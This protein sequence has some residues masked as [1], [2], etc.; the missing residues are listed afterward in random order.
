MNHWSRRR[1]ETIDR[2]ERKKERAQRED[3]AGKLARRVPALATLSIAIHETRPDGVVSDTHDTRRVVLEHAPALFEVPCSYPG[4]TDGG[5]EVTR[6]IL[7]GLDTRRRE[8]RGEQ[9]CRGRCGDIDCTR[10]LRFVCTATYHEG[11]GAIPRAPEAAA[12]SRLIG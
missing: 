9:R 11:V 6:E 3:A 7:D 1:E 12:R 8:F 5:Y 10:V 4:C 2:E